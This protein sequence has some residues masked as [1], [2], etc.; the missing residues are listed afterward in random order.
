MQS[1]KSD[2]IQGHGRYEGYIKTL[3]KHNQLKVKEKSVIWFSTENKEKVISEDNWNG[4]EKFLDS[5]TAIVCYNDQ[6]AVELMQLM[7]QHD[8]NV[9][10]DCSVVSFDNSNLSQ[11]LDV[12]LTT[13]AHPKA[14][15]GIHAAKGL[16]SLMREKSSVIQ[17]VMAPELIIRDTTKEKGR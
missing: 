4:L 17:D 11:S 16:L 5:H 1:S 7:R 10:G 2:D 15:L 8:I 12:K 14:E 9:P 3:R 6:I 13:V